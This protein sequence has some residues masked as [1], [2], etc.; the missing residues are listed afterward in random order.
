MLAVGTRFNNND[1]VL[2]ALKNLISLKIQA[3]AMRLKKA[4]KVMLAK[5][6]LSK[7]RRGN[8]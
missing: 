7:L 4:H 6:E 2:A 8:E 5:C 1:A 3:G